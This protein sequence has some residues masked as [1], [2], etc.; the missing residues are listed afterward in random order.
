MI[1]SG[2]IN[3]LVLDPGF[4]IAVWSVG[5]GGHS[6]QLQGGI[7]KTLVNGKGLK[8]FCLQQTFMVMNCKFL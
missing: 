4:F 3:S 8:V 6:L 5:K 1:S 2:L 7:S